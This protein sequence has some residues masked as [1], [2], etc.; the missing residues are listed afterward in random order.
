MLYNAKQRWTAGGY[1]INNQFERSLRR[2]KTEGK[3]KGLTADETNLIIIDFFLELEEDLEKYR[4][5]DNICPC[6]CELRNS[7]TAAI[8]EMFTRID[9]KSKE[10]EKR[11]NKEFE[12]SI[13]KMIISH[14][15]KDN[16]KY[17]EEFGPKEK[18][19]S[20]IPYLPLCV[21][22]GFILISFIIRYYYGI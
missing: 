21:L 15:E 11:K 2:I 22:F 17:V 3:N 18:S 20:C 4:F 7:G 5:K 14:I 13:N 19:N 6:G 9:K 8:H 1:G 12:Q 10:N 16:A